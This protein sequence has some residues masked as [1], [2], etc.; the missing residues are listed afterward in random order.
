MET[1]LWLHN[2]SEHGD[3]NEIKATKFGNVLEALTSGE[4]HGASAN[5]VASRSCL[6]RAC[7]GLIRREVPSG[8]S[9]RC[10]LAALQR[11]ALDDRTCGLRARLSLGAP[12]RQTI[13]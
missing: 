9:T 6:D 2:D 11:A 13:L 1:P 3:D 12:C 8:R 7:D 5:C 10:P 4:L